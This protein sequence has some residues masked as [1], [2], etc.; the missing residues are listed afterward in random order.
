MGFEFGP[1][2]DCVLRFSS[3]S[4]LHCYSC[5]EHRVWT[6]RKLTKKSSQE[7]LIIEYDVLVF[8]S[9]T[10]EVVRFSSSR[11][12]H[13]QIQTCTIASIPQ[14]ESPNVLF[15]LRT[16]STIPKMTEILKTLRSETY[17]NQQKYVLTLKLMCTSFR[18]WQT[19]I[20][21]A[22]GRGWPCLYASFA[23]RCLYVS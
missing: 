12:K 3:Y 18:T 2:F 4:R 19:N 13:V 14:K 15:I 5:S 8:I 6:F 22:M 1:I 16:N 10:I 21:E 11:P 23:S 9:A 17:N 7:I 20:F